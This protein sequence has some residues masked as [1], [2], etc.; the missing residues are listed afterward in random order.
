MVNTRSR[1]AKN[2]PTEPNAMDKFSD[3]ESDGSVPDILTREQIIEFNNGDIIFS[4]ETI[5]K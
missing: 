4:T 5:L 1:T 2:I 3:D